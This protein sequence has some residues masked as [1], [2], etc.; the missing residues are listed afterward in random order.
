MAGCVCCNG[1]EVAVDLRVAKGEEAATTGLQVA[2]QR[3]QWGLASLRR[4]RVRDHVVERWEFEDL[5]CG[6]KTTERLCNASQKRNEKNISG[7]RAC[8]WCCRE[9][10]WQVWQLREG[11]GSVV[12]CVPVDGVLIIPLALAMGWSPCNGGRCGS[13]PLKM[14]IKK[15]KIK[16]T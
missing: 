12:A 7:L 3:W 11:G 1:V 10:Q 2:R 15:I 6:G 5:A 16:Q 4:H 13:N 14:T 9:W 8:K